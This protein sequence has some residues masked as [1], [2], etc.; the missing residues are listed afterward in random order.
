MGRR[1]PTPGA[2]HPLA[3]A[4]AAEPPLGTRAAKAAHTRKHLLSTAITL[5][6]AHAYDDV[7]VS[8]IARAAGVAHGLVFH[9]FGDKRG[10]YM[11]ALEETTARM[12]ASFAAP[13]SGPLERIRA[14]MAHR[15]RYL[16]EHRGLA[17]RAVL[18]GRGT[19]PEAWAVFEGARWKELKDA[20]DLLGLDSTQPALR[21]VGRTIVALF[22]E[23]TVQWLENHEQPSVERVVDWI[24]TSA[25][26]CLRTATL[27]DP[28]LQL[29]PA[30]DA[31]EAGQAQ[32][33]APASQAAGGR[34]KPSEPAHRAEA[35]TRRAPR[36]KPPR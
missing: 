19:D 34:S 9:H 21:I 22:D 24:M 25:V 29:G 31:L 32:P 3:G 12:N 2:E 36:K 8:D 30:L 7:A 6:S 5:F 15:L 16:A 23:T 17:L 1:E 27:L 35:R 13:E 11:A 4:A 26:A 18:G 14:A 28:N 20:A 33:V 10:I